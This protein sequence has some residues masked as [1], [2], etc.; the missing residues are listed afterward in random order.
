[1]LLTS[2]S[3]TVSFGAGYYDDFVVS[4]DLSSISGDI[5]YV[6]HIHSTTTTTETEVNSEASTSSVSGGY[7]DTYQA[8]S[9]GGCFTTPVVT[10][11]TCTHSL[12]SADRIGGTSGDCP[13]CHSWHDNDA[14]SVTY[15]A[16][17]VCGQTV[18]IGHTHWWSSTYTHQVPV[19][20]GYSRGCGYTN[21]QIISATITY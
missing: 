6:H 16:G 5:E 10:Y 4:T 7:A 1:M 21:G 3:N 19:T 13:V 20:T 14:A 2:S 11:I 8:S 12:R 15:N 17:S 9:K 18:T